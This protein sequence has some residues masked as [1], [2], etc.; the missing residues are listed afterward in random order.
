MGPIGAVI[1]SAGVT[2]L[3]AHGGSWKEGA[4]YFGAIP[5]F[6]SALLMLFARKCSE[7]SDR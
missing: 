6:G 2:A 1:A 3:L 4:L 5:C 7:G